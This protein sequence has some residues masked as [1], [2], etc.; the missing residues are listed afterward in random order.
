MVISAG[1]GT[2]SYNTQFPSSIQSGFQSK[3]TMSLIGVGPYYVKELILRITC[4]LLEDVSIEDFPTMGYFKQS[5]PM[6]EMG[7]WHIYIWNIPVMFEYFGVL[8]YFDLDV[9]NVPSFNT[10]PLGP[11]DSA[12]FCGRRTRTASERLYCRAISGCGRN[13]HWEA[14]LAHFSDFQDWNR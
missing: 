13:Q 5:V 11:L 10:S 3:I 9:L 8:T 4:D 12:I 1:N 6:I 2:I 7:C 14:A